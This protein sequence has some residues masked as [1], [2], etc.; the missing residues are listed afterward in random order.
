MQIG[1]GCFTVAPARA[2]AVTGPA[3]PWKRQ[4]V[5]KKQELDL[6]PGIVSSSRSDEFV[7]RRLFTMEP[8]NQSSWFQL[9]IA[10]LGTIFFQD[11]DPIPTE[12]EIASAP[13]VLKNWTPVKARI[14]YYLAGGTVRQCDIDIGSGVS[15]AVP[16]T[17]KVDIDLLV[18][19]DQGPT[20]EELVADS[21]APGTASAL[22]NTRFATKV[23][24]KATCVTYADGI[25]KLQCSQLV[26]LDSDNLAAS[27]IGAQVPIPPGATSV[28]L[29]V[30][31]LAGIAVPIVPGQIRAQ[32]RTE[33]TTVP[34]N[35]LP[36]ASPTNAGWPAENIDIVPTVSGDAES[37]EVP[38]P[39]S[40]AN[41]IRLSNDPVITTK[42]NVVVAFEI[43]C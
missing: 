19:S 34:Q 25:P 32:F 30:S 23:S 28:Q 43:V 29:H 21:F 35:S 42:A 14:T 22:V 7:G 8:I 37:A 15:V 5:T 9:D 11:G 38:I 1:P 16:P 18:W 17:T 40:F 3:F 4:Y 13:S 10:P 6:S 20:P 39:G 27:G 12:D 41:V 31:N 36:P 33:D 24:A 26:Y 2:I